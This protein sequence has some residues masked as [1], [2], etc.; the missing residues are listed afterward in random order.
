MMGRKSY[1]ERIFKDLKTGR[2]P[3]KDLNAS[4]GSC[5]SFGQKQLTNLIFL[6]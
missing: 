1:R 2:V 3:V 4:E 6:V 5:R